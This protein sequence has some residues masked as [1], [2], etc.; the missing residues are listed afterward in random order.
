MTGHVL[1]VLAGGEHA[2]DAASL[3]TVYLR[4]PDDRSKVQTD[5]RFDARGTCTFSGLADG[6]YWMLI[7][8]KADVGYSVWPRRTEVRFGPGQ[9][10]RVRI[11]AKFE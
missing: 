7:D 3:Y 8:T 9:P 5:G 2:R 11:H 1:Q 4:G 6:R 10:D